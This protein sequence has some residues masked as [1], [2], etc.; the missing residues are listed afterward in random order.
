[1]GL[2]V[3]MIGIIGAILLAVSLYGIQ[4]VKLCLGIPLYEPDHYEE[5]TSA[6]QLGYLYSENHDRRQG[7]WRQTSSNWTG[8]DSGQGTLHAEQWQHS[9][10]PD[11]KTTRQRHTPPEGLG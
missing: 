4:L 11:W 10:S 8:I 2:M 1:M 5:W 7:Q 6:D 9:P 3:P